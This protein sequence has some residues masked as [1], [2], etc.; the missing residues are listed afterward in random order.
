MLAGPARRQVLQQV[1]DG[2]A[3]ID[4]VLDDDHVLAL[5]RPRQVLRDLD[6]ARRHGRV[7]VRRDTD[8]VDDRSGSAM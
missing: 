8:E 6:D 1:V 4:D 7:A 2:V 3:G 5:D